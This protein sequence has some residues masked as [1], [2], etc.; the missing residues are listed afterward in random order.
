MINDAHMEPASH[1]HRGNEDARL[2]ADK[3][4]PEDA[5][6]YADYLLRGET[7]FI[8]KESDNDQDAGQGDIGCK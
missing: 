2:L 7:F 5:D 4:E 6:C 3:K 8:E 1:L